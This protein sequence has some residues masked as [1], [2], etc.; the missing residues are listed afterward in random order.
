MKY[1]ASAKSNHERFIFHRVKN[2]VIKI[3]KIYNNMKQIWWAFLI[4]LGVV[5]IYDP[6]INFTLSL[7]ELV[8]FLGIIG[9][10]KSLF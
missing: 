1:F 2:K 10:I 4:I 8:I 7:A 6:R 3:I 5:M 9:L